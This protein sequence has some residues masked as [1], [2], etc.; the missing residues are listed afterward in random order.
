MKK[1]SS[2]IRKLVDATA[3]AEAHGQDVADILK[4][5]C[6]N[7]TGLVR[8]TLMN[9]V[10]DPRFKLK[11]SV[12]GYWRDEAR[13]G[14]EQLAEQLE[15]MEPKTD[16]GA[17]YMLDNFLN[18][19]L[20]LTFDGYKKEN[21]LVA[22][23]N[24][25]AN[26]EEKMDVDDALNFLEALEK[27]EERQDGKKKISGEGDEEGG[28]S[29]N[30]EEES[31]GENMYVAKEPKN[32]KIEGRGMKTTNSVNT[33]K[34]EDSFL[35]R[36]PLSLIRLARLIGRMG[37]NGIKNRGK[38]LT[39]SKSDIAGIT[40]GNDISAVVP[41]ELSMLAEPKTQDV[42]YRNFTARRLQLFASASLASPA[43]KHHD[44]P[45]IICVDTSSSMGGEPIRTARALAIAVAIIA[46]RRDRDVIMVK[47]SDTYDYMDLGHDHSKLTDVSKFLTHVSQAGNNENA[48]FRW[49]F[50]DIKPNLD[51]YET[52]DILCVSD[53]G[54]TTL[55]AE[56]KS[57]IEEQKK[58]GMTF[59]G[60]N[61]Q[62]GNPLISK[63]NRAYR[64]LS[65]NEFDFGGHDISNP[66][67]VCDSMWTYADGE[68]IEVKKI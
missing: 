55:T 41:S 4:H 11:A 9:A 47:Y 10:C 42:F 31:N 7:D 2:L 68:C 52:A 61:V 25:P 29:G 40:T 1:Y 46:W 45:V 14:L 62:S 33:M 6:F 59:Y 64:M 63:V 21:P 27:V 26:N 5:R 57:I 24:K 37:D 22:L 48:M 53:F 30:A 32:R 56:T 8:Q 18:T 60:L 54:W 13:N 3:E 43:K 15:K 51:A 39:A 67:S 50:K 17:Y 36:I 44:G 49:L 34:I 66:M 38:F 23:L 65:S 28:K 16:E 19:W 12:V 20:H 58:K 35:S